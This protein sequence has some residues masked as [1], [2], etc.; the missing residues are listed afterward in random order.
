VSLFEGIW[1]RPE[2]REP[3]PKDCGGPVTAFFTKPERR[4]SRFV[5][6]V[7]VLAGHGVQLMRSGLPLPVVVATGTVL[8]GPVAGILDAGDLAPF[9]EGDF[10]VHTRESC[11]Q[12]RRSA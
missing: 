8:L 1:N 10:L 7:A 3:V 2:A 5:N 4:H 9:A 11:A 12:I 6:D